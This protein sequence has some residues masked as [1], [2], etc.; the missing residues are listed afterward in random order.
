MLVNF[1]R[2]IR[3]CAQQSDVVGLSHLFYLLKILKNLGLRDFNPA[4]VLNILDYNKYQRYV[5][6]MKQL[7]T[8][9]WSM[10]V[11][12]LD[13][14]NINDVL[15]SLK[16]EWINDNTS[17]ADIEEIIKTSQAITSSTLN[18]LYWMNQAG[19]E[20]DS[21]TIAKELASYFTGDVLSSLSKMSNED[22]IQL[23]YSGIINQFGSEQVLDQFGSNISGDI[24]NVLRPVV[25]I[26]NLKSPKTETT[27]QPIKSSDKSSI[28]I[29]K[30][31][32]NKKLVYNNKA[33]LIKRPTGSG[34]G[35]GFIG[36]GVFIKSKQKFGYIIGAKDSNNIEVLV[37]ND[38]Y[39][40]PSTQLEFDRKGR[41]LPGTDQLMKLEGGFDRFGMEEDDVGDTDITTYRKNVPGT[42]YLIHFDK[43]YYHARHYLGWTEGPVDN[44]LSQHKS[45]KGSPLL[46]ALNN[47]GIDYKIVRTWENV[48]RN[49]E[50]QLK[51]SHNIPRICPICANSGNIL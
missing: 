12:H 18:W 14:Y 23:W 10:L 4:N 51:N 49:F 3:K 17:A 44:R 8:T 45:N 30:L 31:D 46:R 50:R 6:L 2:M 36:A 16:P 7:D 22:Y 9:Q 29:S 34:V 1:I 25:P 32:L 28:D 19:F 42:V 11:N 37:D 24:Y 40:V 39:I 47:I 5:S 26:S 35:I 43:P 38:I 15:L 41:S 48:D 20:L 27:S 33:V 21:L 13:Q